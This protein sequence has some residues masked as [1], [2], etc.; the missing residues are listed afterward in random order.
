MHTG[1]AM[2]MAQSS[3]M[4]F[5]PGH[6][7]K[8]TNRRGTSVE[9]A[10]DEDGRVLTKLYENG[11][12]VEYTYSEDGRM[13]TAASFDA[14]GKT[15]E[16]IQLGF[17]EKKL[18]T[19]I[20]HANGRKIT[21]TYN[22]RGYRKTMSADERTVSYTYDNLGRLTQVL[23]GETVLVSYTYDA[24]GKPTGTQ[25]G[26]GD[27]ILNTYN[28]EGNVSSIISYNAAGTITSQIQ[29]T[30]DKGLM[31]TQTLNE[32]Q[33]SY[34]YDVMGQL[35]RAEFY[36]YTPEIQSYTLEYSYNGMGNR[37]QSRVI[38]SEASLLTDYA[39]DNMNRYTSINGAALSYDQDGNM[40]GRDQWVYEYDDEN[41]LLSASNGSTHY[42]Y[43]YSI[44]GYRS[45]VTLNG[46]RTEY[47]VDPVGLGSVIP[48]MWVDL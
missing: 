36:S 33:W 6:V 22:E 37:T 40:T 28:S 11:E 20:E 26:N 7:R 18:L 46:V 27:Q 4:N 35:V 23:E 38:Q 48:S 13:A 45:A 24:A 34:E 39:V 2:Q 8:V 15:K 21:Y 41:R 43:E 3:A 25:L 42:Q 44:L 19:S 14:E 5:M 17:N 12:R 1:I 32:G 10:S 30:W 16:T 31:Q 9:F 29:Y 47:L